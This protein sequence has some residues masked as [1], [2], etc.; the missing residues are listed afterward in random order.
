[1]TSDA[2]RMV[3][4][5]HH[6]YGLPARAMPEVVEDE[7]QRDL[8]LTLQVEETEELVEA[9]QADDLVR[10]AD[11]LADIVYVAYGTALTYGLDLDDA[12]REVHRSNL[13]KSL[14]E[15]PGGKVR[16]GEDYRPPDLERVLYE[17]VALDLD[18][19]EQL[20]FEYNRVAGARPTE[21]DV[22][23]VYADVAAGRVPRR[24][25]P[26]SLGLG[27][28]GPADLSE[29]EGFGDDD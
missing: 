29:R 2:M 11:A 4:E 16:K 23:R 22:A 24:Q 20:A 12:L 3:I 25:L 15:V 10:T 9:L 17:Q 14:P 13:T 18:G 26:K 7:W 21:A 28:D 19:D 5:F 27:Q 8:R 6:K 1:M